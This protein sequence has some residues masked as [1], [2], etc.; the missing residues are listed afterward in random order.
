[1]LRTPILFIIFNRIDTARRVFEAIRKAEPPRLYVACDGPRSDK[2]GERLAC[3]QTRSLVEEVDWPCQV[4]TFFLDENLGPSK[5]PFTFI[6]WFFQQEEQGIILEHDCLPH[7]D[8]FPYCEELLDK[9]KENTHI[10]AISGPN[11]IPNPQSPYSYTFT[12][13]NHIWGWATWRRT[14]DAYTL[15]LSDVPADTLNVVLRRNFPSF[16]ERAYWRTIFKQIR[17]KEIPTWDYYLT[18]CLWLNDLLSISPTRNLVAN[19]GF[20]EGAINTTDKDSPLANRPVQSILPLVH[21]EEIKRN[22]EEEA[23]YFSQYI[24]EGKSSS[25]LYLKLVLKQLGVFD[26]FFRIKKALFGHAV[27]LK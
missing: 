18:F 22:R 5:G 20:G 17:K 2:E 8:F 27:N 10:G 14:I 12:I 9:Y 23:A 16:R 3:Q 26:T 11:F 6:K 13:Y 25:R 24:M 4:R 1:M 7:P 19:I 21:N 15:D